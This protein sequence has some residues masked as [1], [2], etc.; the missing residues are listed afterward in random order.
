[1][2]NFVESH[3]NHISEIFGRNLREDVAEEISLNTCGSYFIRNMINFSDELLEDDLN[4]FPRIIGFESDEEEEKN[5]D[6]S[7]IIASANAEFVLPVGLEDSTFSRRV[8]NRMSQAIA[9]EESK[10]NIDKSAE[11][12]PFDVNFLILIASTNNIQSTSSSMV[13]KSSSL[14][15]SEEKGI[16]NADP[17]F[18]SEI[19]QD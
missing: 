7:D 8:Q 19:L 11:R 15:N 12:M 5:K 3:K 4:L 9:P 14:R 13:F 1:M 10:R 18:R 2:T 6:N 16:R 17:E